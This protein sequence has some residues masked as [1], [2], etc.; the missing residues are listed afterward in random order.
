MS[1][2]QGSWQQQAQIVS[3]GIRVREMAAIMLTGTGGG[4]TAIPNAFLDRYLPEADGE[5][6][7]I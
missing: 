4:M 3:V 1:Q 7:K 5:Y 6:V 2:D